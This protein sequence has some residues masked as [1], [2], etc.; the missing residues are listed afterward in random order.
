MS[1]IP[2]GTKVRYH[3][4]LT[5]YHGEMV[6]MST[7]LPY[8]AFDETDTVRYKLRYDVGMHDFLEN[9]RPGSFTVLN[10]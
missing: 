8:S 2:K 9:V 6:V 7:H 5:S 4:S 10:D 1:E 3:G